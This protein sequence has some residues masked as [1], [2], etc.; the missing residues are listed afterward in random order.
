MGG[1]YFIGRR[2]VEVLVENNYEVY[3][4]NR[5]TNNVFGEEVISLKCDRNNHIEMK[6][7]LSKYYFDV[8]IDVSGLNKSQSE[9]LY[10][11]L[12]LKWIKKFI[13]LSSSAVYDVENNKTPFSEDT[14]LGRNKY[15]GDYGTNK[16]EAEEFYE[17]VF[18]KTNC[19]LIIL[20]PP[21]VYGEYNYAQRESFIFEHL[22]N[23]RPIIIPNKGESRLQ[24]IYSTDLANIIVRLIES[25]TEEVCIFNVGNKE[26]VTIKEWI[27]YYERVVGKKGK[28]I[29]YDYKSKNIGE[30]DFFPFFD[31]DNVL[32]VNR[33]KKIY[34]IETDFEKGLK[35]AYEW[36]CDNKKSIVFKEEVRRNEIEIVKKEI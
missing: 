12:N 7:A 17:K 28:F 20:R 5:G 34:S 11:S 26:G 35:N 15:W 13:F 16:I 1:S 21:Y 22:E 6:K 32:N 3:T 30:R 19:D 27:N 4:L 36:Y 33:I 23:N 14:P 25:N 10:N 9:I 2:G 18:S 31:Y 24:F 8:V 29:E